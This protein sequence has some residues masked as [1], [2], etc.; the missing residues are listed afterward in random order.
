MFIAIGYL[1]LYTNGNYPMKRTTSYVVVGHR[2]AHGMAAGNTCASFLRAL[3]DHVDEIETDSRVTSDGIIVQLHDNYFV[4]T[5]GKKHLIADSTYSEVKL[6]VPEVMTLSELIKL[7]DKR[8]RLMLEIKP[9]VPTELIINTVRH[10]LAKGWK[11]QDFSFASF[12]YNIL[13][14][15]HR[16]LPEIDRVVLEEWSALRAM[17]RARKLDTKYL[18]MNQQYLWWGFIRWATRH[19]H[20]IYSYPFPRTKLPYNHK[21]PSRWLKHGLHGIITDYPDMHS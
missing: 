10:Y 3:E 1:L 16:A 11:P 15:V 2:G 13:Q 12:D 18:S 5:T 19:N 9:G 6:H 8:A 14:S 7:I 21:K 20:K 4:D 17:R